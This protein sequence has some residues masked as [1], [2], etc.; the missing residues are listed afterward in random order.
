MADIEVDPQRASPASAAAR[1]WADV[2]RATQDHG[3]ATTGGRVST[4]GVAGLTLGGGSGWLERKHGLACDNL[5]AAEL[6]TLGR[7]DRARRRL[8][9]TP[10][11]SGRCAAA[12]GTSASSPRSSSSCT[13]SA[14]RCSAAWRSSP[15]E[16]A[17]GG[18]ARVPRRHARRARRALA[19]LRVSSPRPPRTTS[20]RTCTARRSW[21]SSA[22]GRATSP[23]ASAALAPIR[24]LG[25]DAD[26][27]RPHRTTPTSSARSTTRPATA[28]T[29]R[30]RTSSTCPS[31]AIDAH[32]V[33]ARA[34]HPGRP[35]AAVHRRLGRR[36][37]RSAPEHSPLAGREAG[38]IVHPLMLWEDA[39][40][41]ERCIAL[42]PRRSAPTWS[43]GRPARR[44]RTSSARRATGRMRAAF[45]DSIGRL[46]AVKRAVGPAR[47][48]HTH[49]AV[50]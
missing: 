1:I 20:P 33:R 30:P 48:F 42:R 41:D 13:R 6:V 46:A 23:T 45:G 5:V 27:V 24:A 9:R 49:Q 43:R 44:T 39:A 14:R 7:P 3:L 37:G 2:D 17:A 8:T 15:T 10:S 12:A 40:D 16:R 29:G 35:V 50:V 25:P 47:M 22:C 36:G 18:A 11:C 28:T 34:E 21:R 26:L 32:R 19:G 38:F 31:E 4:T